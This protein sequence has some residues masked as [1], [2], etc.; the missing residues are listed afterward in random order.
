MSFAEGGNGSMRCYIDRITVRGFLL[1]LIVAHSVIA[2]EA[3]VPERNVEIANNCE[4][5]IARLDRIH[6]RAGHNGLVIVIARLGNGERSRGL[7]RR[8]LYNIRTYLNE[9]RGRALRTIITAE[10]ERANDRGRLEIYVAGELVDVL[11]VERG[12]DL[13]VGGCDGFDPRFYPWR[14]RTRPR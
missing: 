7:N 5:N 3:G 4:S 11:G 9:N 8:R 10:G 1:W 6:S 14:D 12:E 13:A 2:Q